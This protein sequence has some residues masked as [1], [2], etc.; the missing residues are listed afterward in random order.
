MSNRTELFG[1]MGAGKSTAF[2]AISKTFHRRGTWVGSDVLKTRHLVAEGK[3]RSWFVGEL[4]Q[5]ASL[6]NVLRK[7]LTSQRFPALA[8]HELDARGNELRPLLQF[9]GDT[10]F[11]PTNTKLSHSII[12]YQIFFRDLLDVVMIEANQ[13]KSSRVLFDEGL[14]QRGIGFSLFKAEGDAW[15]R[16]YLDLIPLPYA[17]VML[18][19]SKEAIKVRLRY[20]DGI[21]SKHLEYFERAIHLSEVASDALEKKGVRVLRIESSH[22]EEFIDQFYEGIDG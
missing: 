6:S 5:L 1:P 15:L 8:W 4:V 16:R 22:E 21:Q 14:I 2:R 10:E 7:I 13:Y 17:A 11:I 20:R 9:L 12:R 18:M 3:A 19:A